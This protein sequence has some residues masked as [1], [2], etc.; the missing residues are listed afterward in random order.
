VQ[1]PVKLY[2]AVEDRK[3]HFRLLDAGSHTPVQQRMVDPDSGEEVPP[4][5]VRK[6]FATGDGRFVLLDEE[7]LEALDPEP[8]RDI[9]VTRFVDIGTIDHPWY[10]RPYYV[11][12]DGD[13]ESYFALAAALA[14]QEKEGIA[15]WVMRGKAYQGA[16]RLEGEHLML[17][18]LRHAGEVV[19]ASELPTPKGRAPEKQELAMAEQL[20]DALSGDFEPEAFRDGYR[21]RVLE[22]VE[23]KAAGKTVRLETSRRKPARDED[24]TGKLAKSLKA[25]K[26]AA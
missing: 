21:E 10:D 1:V 6:G 14:E 9:E 18:T 11:G 5:E 23:A 8:S 16:L 22:L 20:L 19:A 13:T 12:P 24:L 4:E 17:V 26:A 25:A 2:A 3:L 15:R 7:D